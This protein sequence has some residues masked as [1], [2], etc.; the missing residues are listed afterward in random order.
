MKSGLK[1]RT[2]ILDVLDKQPSFDAGTIA[3]DTS[4][5]YSVVMHHLRR[6]KTEGTVNRKGKRPYSWQSTGLGQKRLSS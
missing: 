3:K 6:L 5:S 4:M 2:R 1:A